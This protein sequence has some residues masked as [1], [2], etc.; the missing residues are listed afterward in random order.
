MFQQTSVIGHL[1]GDPELR[2][3][4][5]G[6][7]VASFSV[8]TSKKWMGQDG[9]K[10]EKTVWFRISVWNKQAEI[11]AQYLKKGA[12]VHVIGELE[13]PRVYTGKDG[14]SRASL[15]LRAGNVTFLDSKGDSAGGGDYGAPA[16]AP[17]PVEDDKNIPF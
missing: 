10:Q 5:S 3:L 2:F 12:K 13:E 7:A 11:V 14:V 9:Q 8:A 4:P 6:V 1:G 15:E 17:P 16:K